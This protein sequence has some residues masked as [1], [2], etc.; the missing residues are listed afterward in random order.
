MGDDV[1]ARPFE[2]VVDT[3][4]E[5]VVRRLAQVT[6]FE[7]FDKR[8]GGALDKQKRGRH[9]AQSAEFLPLRDLRVVPRCRPVGL[10]LAIEPVGG[11]GDVIVADEID[12]VVKMMR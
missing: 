9:Q 11:E 2:V 6:R 12:R 7:K 8:C 1:V 3:L 4:I 5:P 10:G